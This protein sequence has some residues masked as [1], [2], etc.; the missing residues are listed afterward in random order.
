MN[1][2]QFSYDSV[3]ARH[4]ELLKEAETERLIRKHQ[5]ESQRSF[6]GLYLILSNLGKIMVNLGTSFQ[7]RYEGTPCAQCT[8]SGCKN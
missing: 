7:K 4:K 6:N 8:Q 5:V 2:F 3:K 1:Y